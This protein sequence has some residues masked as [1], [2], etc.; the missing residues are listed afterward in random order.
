[1][2]QK[3]FAEKL[4][5]LASILPNGQNMSLPDNEIKKAEQR[6]S[7]TFPEALYTFYLRFGKGGNLFSKSLNTIFTPK[8]LINYTVED[9]DADEN[10]GL[11][12]EEFIALGGDLVLAEENQTVWY[13]RL[14]RNTGLPYLDMG[15]GEREDLNMS[16]EDTLLFLLV[17]NAAEEGFGVFAGCAWYLED[18]P[19]N[20]AFL[21]EYFLFLSEGSHA[22]FVSPERKMVGCRYSEEEVWLMAE[23]ETLEQF[24]QDA[25]VELDWW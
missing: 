5:L 19:K 20:K 9:E 24:E 18:T 17:M 13:C 15:D 11:T 10:E 22:V 1:M 8:E 12:E 23:D 6:L 7:T 21:E 2:N 14:D 3:S 25:D 16:L 4:D